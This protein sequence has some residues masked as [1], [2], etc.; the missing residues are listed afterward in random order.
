M[1]MKHNMLMSHMH[2]KYV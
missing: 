2:R 1:A